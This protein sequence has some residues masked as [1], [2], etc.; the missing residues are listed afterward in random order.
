ME[1]GWKDA[2]QGIQLQKRCI[3]VEEFFQT[4]SDQHFSALFMEFPVYELGM[5]FCLHL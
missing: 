5:V 1:P 4:F 2:G 3:P